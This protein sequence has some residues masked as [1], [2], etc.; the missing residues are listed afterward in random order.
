MDVPRAKPDC[1]CDVAG[2]V[3]APRWAGQAVKPMALFCAAA[4][5]THLLSALGHVFPDDH[6]LEKA[7]HLGIV[8]LI[9]SNPLSS[10]VVRTLGICT[11]YRS[12]TGN[13]DIYLPGESRP[14]GH[15]GPHHLE[16]SLL[17]RGAPFTKIS[18]V[19]KVISEGTLIIERYS[20]EC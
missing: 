5:A 12:A 7:D 10:L 17:S 11:S 4:A 2:R 13:P 18:V 3:M 15:R 14:P 1:W 19:L 9:I 6:Y 16:L 20:L 8:A